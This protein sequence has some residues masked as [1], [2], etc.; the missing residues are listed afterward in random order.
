[1]KTPSTVAGALCLLSALAWSVPLRGDGRWEHWSPIQG[2]V[3]TGGLIILATAAVVAMVVR[4]A[5]WGRRLA[6]G[7]AVGQL[8]LAMLTTPSPWWWAAVGLSGATL[9][10]AGGPWAKAFG[11]KRVAHLGPPPRAVLLLCLLACLPVIVA[12]VSINGLEGGWVLVGL[13]AVGAAAYAKAWPGALFAARFLIPAASAAAAVTTPWP[14]WAVALLAGTA[15]TW[16]AWSKDA[17]LAVQP[18]TDTAPA[19][20]PSPTPLRI[21]SASENKPAGRPD[22]RRGTQLG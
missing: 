11:T 16:A 2:L 18:L 5:G 10:M 13:S 17:R 9:A 15:T 6:V 14:G 3:V 21:R 4:N 1:M 8:G 22:Q 7:L 20:S 12:A 19:P